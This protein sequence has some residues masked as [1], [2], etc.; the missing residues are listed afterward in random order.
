VGEDEL[1]KG[2]VVVRDMTS[3]Q[4]KEIRLEA[5]EAELVSKKAN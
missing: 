1:N 3:K 2:A 5:I 4:Q